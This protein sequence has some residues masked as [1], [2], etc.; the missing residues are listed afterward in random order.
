MQKCP[1][2][3]TNWHESPE[4]KSPAERL[5][6]RVPA[7]TPRTFAI[8]SPENMRAIAWLR[9]SLGTRLEATMLPIPKKAPWQSAVMTRA[10][11][12]SAYVGASA[13]ST[14]PAM[15]IPI[16]MSRARVRS[17]RESASATNGEPIVTL[18]A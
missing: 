13:Q 12:S 8:V 5:S 10:V 7:G 11:I 2:D 4:R 1:R 9:S 15:K 18:S 16:R 14:F 17:I 6:K 3:C